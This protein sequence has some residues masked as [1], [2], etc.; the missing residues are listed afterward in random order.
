M[1]FKYGG[2]D[3]EK[4][5]NMLWS[6][7]RYIRIKM[8]LYLLTILIFWTLFFLYSLPLEPVIYGTVLSL[9]VV[10]F[11]SSIHYYVYQKKVKELDKLSNYITHG[12]ERMP[13]VSNKLEELYQLLLKTLYQNK[14]EEL[15]Q[16]VQQRQALEEYFTMWVHQ[17][18]TPI[19]AM[20]L[21]LEDLDDNY[22]SQR[23]LKSE[24][25]QINQYTDMVM[26]YIRL[27]GKTNDF[28]FR[29][30]EIDIIIKQAIRK[31]AA[32]FIRKKL[33]LIYEPVQIKVVTD[34][35]WMVFVMEQLI[36]NALKY[37]SE[38]QVSIYLERGR[39]KVLVIEDSGM[40]IFPED[41]PRVFEQG[42]TGYNGRT[43][44]KA[45][46]IGLYLCKEILNRLSHRIWLESFPGQGTRVMVD[47]EQN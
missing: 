13:D 27:N 25:F 20:G 12:A 8:V 15:N 1:L 37:T 9:Y 24:L 45:T 33:I 10:I 46:G 14:T 41:L 29:E 22:E 17:I 5:Q 21:L 28:T 11:F 40:G 47:L 44:K 42:Y 34:E 6:F 16:I 19:A 36:S 4:K 26:Q 38:G 31:L 2:A 3:I 35:K 23:D 30:Y 18:K 43:D 32:I 7:F 39:K